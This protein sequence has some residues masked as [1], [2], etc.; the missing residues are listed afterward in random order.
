MRAARR[1]DLGVFILAC[2]HIVVART[3]VPTRWGCGL[4]GKT[5]CNW[6][7]RT[8][9]SSC[10]MLERGE[11]PPFSHLAKSSS[12]RGL[13]F[14]FSLRYSTNGDWSGRKL[15]RDVAVDLRKKA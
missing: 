9:R 1:V 8:T 4:C 2:L 6:I 11:A 13:A 15:R 7:S 10:C 3:H 14:L 12:L 5:Q